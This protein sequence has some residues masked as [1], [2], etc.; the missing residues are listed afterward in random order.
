MKQI[1]NNTSTRTISVNE[2]IST[3]EAI[4]RFE[5]EVTVFLGKVCLQLNEVQ[6]G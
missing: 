6:E 1:T 3:E 2:S 5:E 4:L